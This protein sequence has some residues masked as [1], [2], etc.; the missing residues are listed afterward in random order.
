MFALRC[1]LLMVF[2]WCVHGVD[3][4]SGWCVVGV[5]AASVLIQGVHGVLV[6]SWWDRVGGVG[7]VV[8]MVLGYVSVVLTFAS[9]KS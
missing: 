5:S 1:A 3:V 8:L 7:A 6:V 9:L 4:V 2:R